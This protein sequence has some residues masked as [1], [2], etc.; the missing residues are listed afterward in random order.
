MANDYFDSY[1]TTQ[2]KLHIELVIINY[3]LDATLLLIVFIIQGRL[4]ESLLTGNTGCG[5][6]A[7]SSAVAGLAR[8]HRLDI[9][10]MEVAGATDDIL[11]SDTVS[12]TDRSA[13]LERVWVSD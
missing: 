6:A 2:D 3:W 13:V 5:I 10:S 8:F 9:M 11:I 7:T 1:Q 12:F 4:F